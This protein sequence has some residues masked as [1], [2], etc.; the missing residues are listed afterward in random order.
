MFSNGQ[1]QG[2]TPLSLKKHTEPSVEEFN[3][4]NNKANT[5][6]VVWVQLPASFTEQVGFWKQQRRK[7]GWSDCISTEAVHVKRVGREKAELRMKIGRQSG[8][9]GP[10]DLVLTCNPKIRRFDS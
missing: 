7:D 9:C 6:R 4:K 5:S 10:V 8:W 1:S 3:S 2:N